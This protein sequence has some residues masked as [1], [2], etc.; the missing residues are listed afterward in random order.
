M[1]KSGVNIAALERVRHTGRRH[2]IH[3]INNDVLANSRA[4]ADDISRVRRASLASSTLEVRHLD[5]ADRE[6]RSQWRSQRS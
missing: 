5:V 4:G 1:Q 6:V 2:N 3:I